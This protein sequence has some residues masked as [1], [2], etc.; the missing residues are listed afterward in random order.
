MGRIPGVERHAAAREEA[1]N[2][3]HAAHPAGGMQRRP[4]VNTGSGRVEPECEHEVGGVE[5]LVEDRVCQVSV[6]LVCRRRED[7]RILSE[8]GARRVFVRGQ[9]GV[10]EP[11]PCR[12]STDE[13]IVDLAMAE[14]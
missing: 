1:F 7:R 13:Q 8:D 9:E 2:H 14:L 5:S 3:P 4:A 12:A 6:I 10:H 11:D